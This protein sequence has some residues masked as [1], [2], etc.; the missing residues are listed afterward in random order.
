M[1]MATS[2]GLNACASVKL[3]K[4]DLLKL[5]EFKEESENIGAYPNVQDAP[6]L[7]S[8]VRNA[9]EWDKTANE[10][11]KARDNINTPTPIEPVQTPEQIQQDIETLKDRVNEYRVDDPR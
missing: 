8:D 7:P 9:R 4:L 1:A 2:F 11:L 3:P 5:P 6:S 10:I